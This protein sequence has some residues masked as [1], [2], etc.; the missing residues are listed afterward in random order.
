MR[1]NHIYWSCYSSVKSM[2]TIPERNCKVS[3]Q[4]EMNTTVQKAETELRDVCF[5]R[6]KNH[7]SV[8]WVHGHKA[9]NKSPHRSI[10][11]ARYY[12]L[13]DMRSWHNQQYPSW[14]WEK[15]NWIDCVCCV[16]GNSWYNFIDTGQQSVSWVIILGWC[17]THWKDALVKRLFSYTELFL[18]HNYELSH[19]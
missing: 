7:W 17:M 6:V 18:Y 3:L 8:P 15:G 5:K 11:M 4:L 9:D 13:I 10:N 12:Q 2:R 19:Y 14:K 1:S 16:C